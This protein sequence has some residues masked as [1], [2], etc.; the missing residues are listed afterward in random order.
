MAL[1]DTQ[2]D[3]ALEELERYAQPDIEPTLDNLE[4][5]LDGCLRA[6]F[7]ITATVYAVGDV[8]MPTTRNGHRY[9]CI[10]GGTSGAT[11]PTW[12]LQQGVVQSDGS[13]DPLL[14][15]QEDGPDYDN[16]YD[17]KAAAHKAW[18]VKAS[19]AAELTDYSIG[20][21]KVS[22]SQVIDHCLKMADRYAP[23]R[24]G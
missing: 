24:M 8:V 23:L 15:W 20:Q 13:S 6:S 22:E 5:I 19:K 18:L 7:W 9:R 14:Y 4:E 2:K 17:V 3:A 16:V 11:E 10:Q 1:I 12:A 21:Q